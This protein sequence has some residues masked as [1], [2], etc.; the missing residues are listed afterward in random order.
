M[1][2]YSDMVNGNEAQY[3]Q[4]IIW[5]PLMFCCTW[6]FN[7]GRCVT[8]TNI[9]KKITGHMDASTESIDRF[10]ND[11]VHTFEKPTI[12]SIN[13]FMETKLKREM[14]LANETIEPYR[15]RCKS[16][17]LVWIVKGN[18]SRSVLFSILPLKTDAIH[19]LT[20]ARAMHRMPNWQSA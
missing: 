19:V 13:P 17:R 4:Y 15:I 8:R 7:D 10:Q 18:Y 20:E 9:R 6:K 5:Y 16:K 1:V 11:V 12:Q 2:N 3:I 14:L